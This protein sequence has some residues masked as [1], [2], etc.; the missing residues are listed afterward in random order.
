MSE[1]ENESKQKLEVASPLS[2]K[3]DGDDQI[4][5]RATDMSNPDA[6]DGTNNEESDQGPMLII[7]DEHESSLE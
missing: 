3:A 4:V 6:E 5:S 2:S 1:A 7:A